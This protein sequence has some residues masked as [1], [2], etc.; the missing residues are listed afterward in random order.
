LVGQSV[1]FTVKCPSRS[2]VTSGVATWKTA[3]AQDCGSRAACTR[4]RA[5]VHH[6]SGQRF[7]GY[8]GAGRI[9]ES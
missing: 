7:D 1:G 3:I 9:F 4:R 5:R 2:L 8:V 6:D